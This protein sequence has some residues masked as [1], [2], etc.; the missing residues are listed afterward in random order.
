MQYLDD[1]GL[2]YIT[3]KR[4]IYKGAKKTDN[5][6]FDQILSLEMIP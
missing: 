3:N 4:L 6:K 5:M 1:K 2:L